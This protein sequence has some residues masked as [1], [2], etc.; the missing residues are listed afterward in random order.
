MCVFLDES[1]GTRHGTMVRMFTIALSGDRLRYGGP[2][3]VRFGAG[4]AGVRGIKQ[5]GRFRGTSPVF[6][7][8]EY[9]FV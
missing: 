3:G 4:A 6:D 9:Y 2:R 8:P 1:K 5:R 7:N